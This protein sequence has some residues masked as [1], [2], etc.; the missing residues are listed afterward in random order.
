MKTRTAKIYRNAGNLEAA[1]KRLDADK[2]VVP[3]N[4]DLTRKFV[5]TWMA[6]GFTKTRGV[7]LVYSLRKLA[8]ILCKPFGQA[9][10]DDVIV[11]VTRLEDL[12]PAES[13]KYD[14]NVVLKTFYRWLKG[15]DE[16]MPPEVSWLKPRM[17]NRRHKL[18]E[19]LLTEN[20]VLAMAQAASTARDKALVLGMDFLRKMNLTLHCNPGEDSA[21]FE[22]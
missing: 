19:D 17:K 6:K 5:N 3:E 4:K 10:K 14:L 16:T 13:T 15:N 18:P 20:E 22:K 11:L 21:Y 8:A 7:K 2:A 1:F 12:D 9:T